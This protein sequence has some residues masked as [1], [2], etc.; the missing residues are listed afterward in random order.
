M[1]RSSYRF[2]IICFVIVGLLCL[3]PAGSALAAEPEV[4]ARAAL[5]LDAYTGRVLWQQQGEEPLPP[6]STTKILTALLCLDL[7]PLERV[8]EV[9]PQAAAVGE[10][11][12]GLLTGERFPLGE[13]LDAALLKSANDACFAMAEG[14]VGSEPYFVRLMNAKAHAL[15]ADTAS[16]YNTNGLPAEGHLLSCHDLALLAR[17]AMT[18]EEFAGRVGSLYATMEGGSYNRRL[19]NTNKLLTMAE[20]VD[21]IKT[22]TTNA[23]GPC[24][25]SSMH[26]ESGGQERRV[27]AVVLHSPDRY[28]DSL[29]LLNFGLEEFNNVRL[30]RRGQAYAYLPLAGYEAEGVWLVAEGDGWA[31]LKAGEQ[32]DYEYH[33]RDLAGYGQDIA[34]GELLGTLEFYVKNA[35][36]NNEEKK[37]VLCRTNLRAAAAVR[38]RGRWGR[39]LALLFGDKK[40]EFVDE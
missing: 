12:A 37:E 33:L 39:A 6:A 10:S 34:A 11:S 19:K 17:E 20:G 35:D 5:V 22:G 4:A 25:V 2:G 23:A 14:V 29:A 9:S 36:H 30:V 27:I 21:G 3:L 15:G 24:L 26:R 18:R 16:L 28:K 13:L 31:T 38:H 40:Q 1:G 32:P 8:V 7:A